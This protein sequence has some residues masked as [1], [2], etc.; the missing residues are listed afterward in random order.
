MYNEYLVKYLVLPYFVWLHILFVANKLKCFE[1]KTF[2]H[3]FVP[4]QSSG[5]HHTNGDS[6]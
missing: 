2:A 4:P 3:L 6:T 1:T 5:V